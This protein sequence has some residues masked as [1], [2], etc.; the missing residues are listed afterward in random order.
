MVRC[1][2]ARSTSNF[3]SARL[4]SST[5]T[6]PPYKKTCWYA[7]WL[8]WPP[9]LQKFNTNSRCSL[10]IG[11]FTPHDDQSTSLSS[12]LLFPDSFLNN[13]DGIATWLRLSLLPLYQNLDGNGWMAAE[14]LDFP[15]SLYGALPSSLYYSSF[16]IFKTDVE[17][18][19]GCTRLLFRQ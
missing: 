8:R 17:R 5:Q 1:E 4:L 9:F 15:N 19:Y 16:S 3:S 7:T 6:P 12:M 10:S 11:D 2:R 14:V 18:W 13:K